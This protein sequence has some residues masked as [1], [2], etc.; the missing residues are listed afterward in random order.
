A[1]LG[2]SFGS[3]II[4][5]TITS[6]ARKNLRSLESGKKQMG[7]K[8][9]LID[10]DKAFRDAEKEARAEVPK[11]SGNVIIKGGGWKYKYTFRD[12]Q[13]N[14]VPAKPL[15]YESLINLVNSITE[16]LS[17]KKDP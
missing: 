5:P 9:K 1:S 4:W 2:H 14:E 8:L 10:F 16:N 17:G 3:L 12:E 13:G 11:K 6:G 7:N 15:T